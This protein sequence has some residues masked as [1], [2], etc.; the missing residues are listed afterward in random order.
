M[1]AIIHLPVVDM[2]E[3][4]SLQSKLDSQAIF[5]E[6]IQV[7]ET[8]RGWFLITTSD[9][10]SGWVKAGSFVKRDEPYPKDLQTTRLSA[11]VYAAPD[12]EYGP[13]LTLPYGSKLKLL[14]FED[15][16]WAKV[17]LPDGKEAF[18]QKG[19]A[20]EELFELISFSK[21]FL[22]LPYLW[23]GRS[24]FGYDCSG[25][26]QMLYGSMG[27]HLPRNARDQILDPHCNLV[28]L[29]NLR[30]CDLIFWGKSESDIRHVGMCI[31]G[32]HFIH[33]SARENK[34]YLRISHLNDLEWSARSDA[35]Y[36]FREARR[37]SC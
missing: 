8:F 10:Y 20:V 2:R 26:I 7:R 16:R 12:I 25:F 5:G 19:D 33:A 36:P 37:L 27:I 34:P 18:L 29:E 4:P 28:T 15:Q 14:D 31:E 9:D 30:P 11:H 22:G 13:L 23:G 3:K 24:S 17:Q 35:F 1:N 21:K 6:E 32:S